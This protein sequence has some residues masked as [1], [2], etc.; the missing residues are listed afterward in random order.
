MKTKLAIQ[1]FDI[2]FEL[3]TG[4]NKRLKSQVADLNRDGI[5][6]IGP[7]YEKC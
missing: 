6:K 7:Q 2:N 4:V 5:E 1:R 3:H